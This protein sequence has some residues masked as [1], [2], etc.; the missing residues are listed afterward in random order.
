MLL[1]PKA[2]PEE[3]LPNPN[4]YE[5][6]V[7]GAEMV[8]PTLHAV[9]TLPIEELRLLVATNQA[10]LEIIRSGLAKQCRVIPYELD[11]TNS[12]IVNMPHYYR[13]AHAFDAASRLALLE[14]RTNDAAI[15][16]LDCT[17]FGVELARGGVGIDGMTGLA[18]RGIGL[19]RLKEALPGSDTNTVRVIITTLDDIVA[20]QESSDEIYNREA[21]WFGYAGLISELVARSGRKKLGV[22]IEEKNATGLNLLQHTKLRAAAHAYELD[23]AKPPATASNLVPQYLKSV[24]LDAT[25]GKELLLD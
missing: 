9:T 15:L 7:K 21:Q 19:A 2:V 8:P 17:R 18:I 22:G 10:A 3:P 5:D 12:T 16:A 20:R 23:H 1:T 25:T 13:A 11:S 24:P 6:L 4:G 14:S